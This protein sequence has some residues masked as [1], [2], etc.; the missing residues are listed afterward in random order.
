M[1]FR[2]VKA[3]GMYMGIKTELEAVIARVN[4]MIGRIAADHG[5]VINLAPAATAVVR[6]QVA[7]NQ[8]DSAMR[9][10]WVELI[11][12]EAAVAIQMHAWCEQNM[13]RRKVVVANSMARQD[14]YYQ[15]ALAALNQL[16]LAQDRMN[17]I[18]EL[19]GAFND[20]VDSLGRL[21]AGDTLALNGATNW[22]FSI[23]DK[24]I[25][26]E[27]AMIGAQASQSKSKLG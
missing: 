23:L 2:Q 26:R 9:F 8:D 22:V 3:Q 17:S 14:S 25:A 10:S 12:Q 13:D 11:V 1:A 21:N 24:L 20:V 27:L 6:A 18:P 15:S 5:P 16:Q 4:A 7:L 19:H